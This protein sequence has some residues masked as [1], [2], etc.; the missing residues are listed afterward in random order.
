[1]FVKYA[2]SEQVAVA[3]S[4]WS[5]GTD[6]L[7]IPADSIRLTAEEEELMA[8]SVS[9]YSAI[10]WGLKNFLTGDSPMTEWDTYIAQFYDAGVEEQCAIYQTAYERWLAS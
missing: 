6:E 1:M 9:D 10:I 4:E 7:T 2:Y 3:I 8:N 5:K